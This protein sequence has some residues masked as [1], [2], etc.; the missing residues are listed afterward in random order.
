[1][2]GQLVA[3]MLMQFL[4]ERARRVS[5]RRGYSPLIV[6]GESPFGI[7]ISTF[8]DANRSQSAQ[9]LPAG[10]RLTFLKYEHAP[11]ARRN[12]TALGQNTNLIWLAVQL[13]HAQRRHDGSTTF[14]LPLASL[15]PRPG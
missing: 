6:L 13:R 15:C 9:P 7:Q 10:S 2:V 3:E 1:M 5:W 4:I 8:L 11:N 14:D 12:R